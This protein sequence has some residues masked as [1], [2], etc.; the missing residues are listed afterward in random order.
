[1]T[2]LKIVVSDSSVLMDLAKVRLIE[3][4]LAL[5]FEFVIPDVIF[6]EELLDLGTYGRDDLVRLGFQIG[7]LEGSDAGRAFV[8][9]REHRRRLSLND[10]FAW[11]LAEV[12]RGILMSGDGDLRRIASDSGVEVHGTLWAIG[13]MD[14]HATC[15]RPELCAALELLDGDPLVR[16]PRNVLRALRMKL[17]G[18]R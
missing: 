4:T 11:R 15:S 7:A 2:R 3:P 9:F 14:R 17:A 10:C 12:S 16:L 18:D 6:A 5:P 8:Y 1:M 13:L